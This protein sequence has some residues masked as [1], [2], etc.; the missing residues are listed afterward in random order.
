M[1]NIAISLKVGLAGE[2][3]SS[4]PQ[5]QLGCEALVV[6]GEEKQN[7]TKDPY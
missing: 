2:L 5:D 7:K 1:G 3:A 4:F 6:S